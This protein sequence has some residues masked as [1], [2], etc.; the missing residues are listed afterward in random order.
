MALEP[1]S[2]GELAVTLDCGREQIVRLIAS[3]GFP[4]PTVDGE[5]WNRSEV[6]AWLKAK[7]IIDGDLSAYVRRS[8]AA[9]LIGYTKNYIYQLVELGQFPAPVYIGNRALWHRP[10]VEAWWRD[11]GTGTPPGMI[12]RSEL[13]VLVG[14]SYARIMQLMR[15]DEFPQPVARRRRRPFWDKAQVRDWVDHRRKMKWRELA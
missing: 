13:L 14:L 6:V 7:G 9:A 5:T 1:L 12:N 4:R 3:D 8:V 11:N 15:L 2:F 10:T